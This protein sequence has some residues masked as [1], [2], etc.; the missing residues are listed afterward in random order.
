MS[1]G[2]LCKQFQPI[3]FPEFP[4]HM[5]TKYLLIISLFF[6][7]LQ[8]PFKKISIFLKQLKTSDG[9]DRISAKAGFKFPSDQLSF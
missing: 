5:Q 8:I 3:E 4:L 9:N 1:L 2:Q 7:D 6:Y